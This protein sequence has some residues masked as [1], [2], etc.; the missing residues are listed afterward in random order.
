MAKIAFVRRSGP[1]SFIPRHEEKKGQEA[2]WRFRQGDGF[3]R[4]PILLLTRMALSTAFLCIRQENFLS[5]RSVE[6]RGPSRFKNWSSFR[7]RNWFDP[8]V[9]RLVVILIAGVDLLWWLCSNIRPGKVHVY[10]TSS[11]AALLRHFQAI[12]DPSGFSAALRNAGQFC[13]RRGI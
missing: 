11:L 6:G 9:N 7:Q 3:S 4:L 5:Q 2:I 12:N 1:A 10:S 13:D 8:G